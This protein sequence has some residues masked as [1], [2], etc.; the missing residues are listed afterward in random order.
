MCS[1]ARKLLAVGQDFQLIIIPGLNY[2]FA[3]IIGQIRNSDQGGPACTAAGTHRNIIPLN[4]CRK[5][6]PYSFCCCRRV[7]VAVQCNNS[8]KARSYAKTV[9]RIQAP[10][11]YLLRGAYMSGPADKTDNDPVILK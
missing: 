9:I 4:F 2:R 1:A 6:V 3:E 8:I 7:T 5:Q 10:L 11:F